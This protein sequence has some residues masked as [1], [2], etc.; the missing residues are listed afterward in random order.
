LIK[1]RVS[2]RTSLRPHLLEI[3]GDRVQLHQ[4]II[5]LL[6][7]KEAIEPVTDLSREL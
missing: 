2:L 4:V 1:H 6:M 5:N 7:N 3:L